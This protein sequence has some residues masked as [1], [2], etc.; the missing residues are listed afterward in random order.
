[1]SDK[2]LT[3]NDAGH[4]S[5]EDDIEKVVMSKSMYDNL[6]AQNKRYREALIKIMEYACD[7]DEAEDIA[8]AALKDKE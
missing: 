2:I 8:Q 1:M 6:I 5:S 7:I 4:L 3:Y